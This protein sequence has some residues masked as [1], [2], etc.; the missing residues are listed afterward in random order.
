MP[1]IGRSP[2]VFTTTGAGPVSGFSNA[3]SRIDKLLGADIPEWRF[4]DLRRSCAS[5]MQMLGIDYRVI[6]ACLNHQS[7]TKAG[8]I[9]RYQRFEFSDAKRPAF[10]RLS[11]FLSGLIAGEDANALIAKLTAPAPAPRIAA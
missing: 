7:G 11:T 1:M 8:L 6:E 2:F 4:H 10:D 5:L 3:K 9:G